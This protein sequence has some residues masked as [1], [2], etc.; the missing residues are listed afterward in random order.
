MK[1]RLRSIFQFSDSKFY[2]NLDLPFVFVVKSF[3]RLWPVDRDVFHS[4]AVMPIHDFPIV[5][6]GMNAPY[7][8]AVHPLERVAYGI[9]PYDDLSVAN[10]SLVSVNEFLVLN[11]HGTNGIE[12]KK[13][14]NGIRDAKAAQTLLKFSETNQ[15]KITFLFGT[16]FLRCRS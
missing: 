4:S 10:R 8:R 3:Y 14:K 1:E 12:I 6:K 16:N 15:F 7:P 13:K 2:F 5:M 11:Y 9:H